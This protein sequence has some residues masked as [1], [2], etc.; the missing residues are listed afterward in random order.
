M[1]PG[2][3]EFNERITRELKTTME[4]L[5]S[6]VEGKEK[7]IRSY[8]EIQAGLNKRTISTD[9]EQTS[10]SFIPIEANTH[11][12]TLPKVLAIKKSTVKNKPKLIEQKNEKRPRTLSGVFAV[13]LI[14]ALAGG[15]FYEKELKPQT[16]NVQS[17][18]TDSVLGNCIA[19][20]PGTFIV[21]RD[22]QG[23][24]IRDADTTTGSDG[25]GTIHTGHD[26]IVS[27]INPLAVAAPVLTPDKESVCFTRSDQDEEG[28]WTVLYSADACT[29]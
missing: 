1:S 15:L 8:L 18:L 19:P 5:N 29:R 7:I 22:P 23:M 25:K 28:T 21:A 13:A 16:L 11:S 12:E 26:V 10:S 24:Y 2:T 3:I 27:D 17:C 6:L 9:L 20:L 4:R 14:L